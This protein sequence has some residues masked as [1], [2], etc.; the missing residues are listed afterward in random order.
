M[1]ISKTR[2]GLKRKPLGDYVSCCDGGAAVIMR[3]QAIELLSSVFGDFELLPLVSELGEYS[4][5]NI[6]TVLDCIDY[7]NAEYSILPEIEKNAPPRILTYRKYAFR[8]EAIQGHHIFRIINH[9][10]SGMYV[11]DVFVAEVEK[12]N[13]TGFAFKQIWTDEE[14][15]QA[16]EE[17]VIEEPLVGTMTDEDFDF[18]EESLNI[19][20]PETYKSALRENRPAQCGLPLAILSDPKKIVE[21]NQK[22][23]SNG[24]HR[25]LLRPE[26]FVC[27]YHQRDNVYRFLDLSVSDSP[28]Y[29]F[30]GARKIKYSPDNLARNKEFNSLEHFINMCCQM[31]RIY[32]KND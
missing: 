7:E 22:L 16:Q 19:T 13:L 6:M 26:H 29:K 11:D 17:P 2:K 3:H 30:G 1:K 31:T 12:H 25:I 20:L 23:R 14:P 24:I 4:V 5:V 9:P 32:Q 10:K 21:V 28:L 8:A 27:C 18:I 15:A